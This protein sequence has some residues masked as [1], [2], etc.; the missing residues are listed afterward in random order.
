MQEKVELMEKLLKTLD[1]CQNKGYDINIACYLTGL[2][3]LAFEPTIY[4]L[5]K[6]QSSNT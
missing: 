1:L 4:K 2:D 6:E 5:L 3:Y